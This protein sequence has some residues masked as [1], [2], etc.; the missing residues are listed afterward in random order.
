[1]LAFKPLGPR[2]GQRLR[3]ALVRRIYPSPVHSR[4]AFYSMVFSEDDALS[5]PSE[6]LLDLSMLAIANA[7]RTDLNEICCRLGGRFSFSD[8]TPNVWPGTHYRLLAGFVRVLQPALIVEIGTAEGM[9]A[10]ALRKCLPAAGKIVTFDLVPWAEYPRS[11]LTPEDFAGGELRQIIADVGQR[12]T[13]ERHR[14]TFS[15][16][17]LI[18]IDAAKDGELEPKLFSWFDTLEFKT[19]PIFVLDDIRLWNMLAVWRSLKWP[20]LDLTSFGH[21]C[22]TGLCERPS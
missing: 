20:K 13:L 12:E 2:F 6:R 8:R 14:E 9:S 10:L 18:F 17:D 16:A 19:N 21:W 3:D 11:C 15:N 1:M 4:H 7:R 22:G 5:K